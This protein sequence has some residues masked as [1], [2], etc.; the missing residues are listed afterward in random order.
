MNLYEIDAAIEAC[1]D[2]ETGEILDLDRL[3]ALNMDRTAKIENVA[4]WCSNLESDIS[5]LKEQEEYFKSRRRQAEAK[6]DGLKQWLAYALGGQKFETLKA[7]VTF[8]KGTTVKVNEEILPAE[9]WNI[10][11]D[12]KPDLTAVKEALNAGRIID[13][14]WFEESINPQINKARRQKEC[15]SS[16]C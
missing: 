10:T 13:G 9:F 5:G 2:G 6:L 8:R 16:D 12:R 3:Q 14:A 15:E 7:R 11:E 4:L 1:I